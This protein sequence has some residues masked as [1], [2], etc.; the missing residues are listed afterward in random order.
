[1]PR[2][3]GIGGAPHGGSQAE[4]RLDEIHPSVVK[5]TVPTGPWH[6]VQDYM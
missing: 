6:Q 2:L 3:E 5:L 4:L 1:M